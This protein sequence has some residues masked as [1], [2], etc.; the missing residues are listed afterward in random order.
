[1]KVTEAVRSRT[2]RAIVL[3]AAALSL[4]GCAPNDDPASMP[5]E[6]AI[7]YQVDPG[8]DDWPVLPH[9]DDNSG[10]GSE[11]IRGSDLSNQVDSYARQSGTSPEDVYSYYYNEETPAEEAANDHDT[12]LPSGSSA[13]VVTVKLGS[14]GQ[15]HYQSS[16]VPSAYTSSSYDNLLDA[17][18]DNRAVLTETMEDGSMQA[19][20]VRVFEPDQHTDPLMQEP[21]SGGYFVETDSN[22]RERGAAYIYL[23]AA[24]T[25]SKEYARLVI[26]HE[27]RHS[28]FRADQN[29]G[30]EGAERSAIAD[31]CVS[32]RDL[33]QNEMQSANG[34]IVRELEYLKSLAP[35]YFRPAYDDVIAEISQGVRNTTSARQDEVAGYYAVDELKDCYWRNPYAAVG[36]AAQD[37]GLQP[38]N[39]SDL[40]DDRSAQAYEDAANRA[41]EQW[42]VAIKTQT[43]Y[44]QLNESAL[45]PYSLGN[46]E[47]GHSHDNAAEFM[48]S[49]SN[50]IEQEPETATELVRELPSTQ[51]QAIIQAA[52]SL[53]SHISSS[54]NLDVAYSRQAYEAYNTFFRGLGATAD[55]PPLTSV[56]SGVKAG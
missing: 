36:Q 4:V 15:L 13:P 20:H 27:T 26:G 50:I 17:I 11:Y 45:L 47:L 12:W 30:M 18:D 56:A 34:A 55:L 41:V 53:Y 52:R 8:V 48:T 10:H 1:M 37:M 54:H 6:V 7:Q 42:H 3:G 16:A 19:L 51:Q 44:E 23:A 46:Q 49:V 33:A 14:D 5:Q 22:E 28:I 2:G 43:I 9:M 25:M 38:F 24:D 35:E 32:L 40:L 29:Q 39:Y 21:E 31:A